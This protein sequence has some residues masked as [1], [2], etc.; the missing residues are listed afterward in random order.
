MCHASLHL[1]PGQLANG[2]CTAASETG[3]PPIDTN[4][5]AP[6]GLMRRPNERPHDGHNARLCHAAFRHHC[7]K[8][9]KREERLG[10]KCSS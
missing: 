9:V 5:R 3:R 7:K 8:E 1:L 4:E 6:T 10:G 2:R